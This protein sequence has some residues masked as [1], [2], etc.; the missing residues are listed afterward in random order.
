MDGMTMKSKLLIF[1]D[2]NASFVSYLKR[3]EALRRY[4][5]KKL[6]AC[7]FAGCSTAV[8]NSSPVP[9]NDT[10]GCAGLRSCDDNRKQPGSCALS[11]P[12]NDFSQD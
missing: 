7:E 10:E 2:E 12:T 3:Q 1:P 4:T 9:T 6:K 5:A 8:E 11:L